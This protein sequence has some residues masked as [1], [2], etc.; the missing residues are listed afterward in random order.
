MLE[1]VESLSALRDW[2]DV[3]AETLRR[4]AALAHR[5]HT[6]RDQ[7]LFRRGDPDP[8]LFVVASG[9]YKVSMLSTTGREQI[10]GLVDAGKLVCDGYG[11]TRGHSRVSVVAREAASAWQ[12][13]AHAVKLACR[14]DASLSAA[15]AETIAHRCNRVLDLVYDLSLRSVEQ[16]VA[17]FLHHLAQ[18]IPAAADGSVIIPRELN[19]NTVAGM[20]GTT[21]EELT[22]TQSRLQKANL[23]AVTRHQLRLLDLPALERLADGAGA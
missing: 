10:V 17:A 2:E 9:E 18:R 16:R 14:Q 19:V 7:A 20:L 5:V 15:V 11:G 4:F 6:G 1:L 12:F 22:R 21:R 3:P 8:G 13:P 23:I